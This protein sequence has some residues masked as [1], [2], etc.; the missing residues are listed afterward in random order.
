MENI[1]AYGLES[2]A[3]CRTYPDLRNDKEPPDRTQVELSKK[4]I[5]ENCEK[6]D[7]YY[8]YRDYKNHRQFDSYNFKHII[9]RDLGTYIGNGAFIQAAV[10]LSY[11]FK[12]QRYGYDWHAVFKMGFKTNYPSKELRRRL[13]P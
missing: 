4:W 13:Q 6:R 11:E 1:L 10:E 5:M 9:E 3:L 8:S 2:N 7:K 12:R